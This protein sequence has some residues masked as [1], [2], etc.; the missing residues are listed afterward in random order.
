MSIRIHKISCMRFLLV[1]SLYKGH[2][3]NPALSVIYHMHAQ[4]VW[5][6]RPSACGFTATQSS[7]KS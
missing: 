4:L 1:S 7:D 3:S 2:L 6:S 5:E